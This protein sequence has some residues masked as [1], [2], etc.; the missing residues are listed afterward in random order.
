MRAGILTNTHIKEV[1]GAFMDSKSLRQ[2]EVVA[3]FSSDH[4]GETLS[5]ESNG[6]MI[7]VSYEPIARL[8]EECRKDRKGN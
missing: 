1:R 4:R 3:R 7:V 6:V 5:F 8:I 2:A